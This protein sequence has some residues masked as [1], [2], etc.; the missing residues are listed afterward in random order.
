MAND[1]MKRE[2]EPSIKDRSDLT[3]PQKEEIRERQRSFRLEIRQ[4]LANT[5]GLT[6]E[7][8]VELCIDFIVGGK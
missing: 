5:P 4:K 6:L 1:K 7:E 2:F 8:K 3:E